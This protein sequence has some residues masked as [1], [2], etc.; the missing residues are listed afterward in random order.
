MGSH[1]LKTICWYSATLIR[2]ASCNEKL[3]SEEAR[4]GSNLIDSLV[5]PSRVHSLQFGCQPVK[6]CYDCLI[7]GKTFSPVMLSHEQGVKNNQIQLFVDPE[8]SSEEAVLKRYGSLILSS[9]TMS[10]SNR[11]VYPLLAPTGALVAMIYHY[12]TV[13]FEICMQ[14]SPQALCKCI[15]DGRCS[16]TTTQ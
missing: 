13:N 12:N 14:P 4:L 8:V 16:K 2:L 1:S 6:I 9:L 3:E 15:Q 10:F 11:W 7:F 5:I